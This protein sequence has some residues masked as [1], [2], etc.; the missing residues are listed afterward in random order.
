MEKSS[1]I[2][3]T[4]LGVLMCAAPFRARADNA[5]MGHYGYM[6]TYSDDYS[7]NPSFHGVM[8]VIDIFP[9]SCKGLGTRMACAKIGMVE[10]YAIPKAL[11]AKEFGPKNLNAYVAFSL[12]DAKKAGIETHVT[13]VK[14]AGFPAAIIRMPNH[15]QPLNTMV[16][17]EGTKVYYRF[18]FNDKTGAG[19]ARAMI[20]SLKENSPHDNPPQ[21]P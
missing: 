5:F 6:L 7:P 19:A 13:R 2:V 17:I 10:V 18:K 21:T 3:A 12:G 11:V 8:E 20:D 14:R 4:L 1:I 15:P 9:R 16:L